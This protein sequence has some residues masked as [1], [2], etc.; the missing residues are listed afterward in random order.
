M[1]A[2][3]VLLLAAGWQQVST[4]GEKPG[5]RATCT[6]ADPRTLLAQLGATSSCIES[7]AALNP[8]AIFGISPDNITQGHRVQQRWNGKDQVV[9]SDMSAKILWNR[10]AAK[11]KT[12]LFHIR[13]AKVV[14]IEN[15]NI[16]T[17][18]SDSRMYDTIHIENANRV[19]VRNSRFAGSVRHYHLRFDNVRELI[20]ENVEIA[21]VEYEGLPGFRGGGGIYFRSKPVKK[22]DMAR[23]TAP[24]WVEISGCRIHDYTAGEAHRNHDGIN[25]DSPGDALIHNCEIRNWGR[26][27]EIADAA[28]DV[29]YRLPKVPGDHQITVTGNRIE[30]ASFVKTPGFGPFTNTILWE[31][32]TFIDTQVADYHGG[33]STV[34]RSN[35]FLLLSRDKFYRMW[36]Q[37]TAGRTI[38]EGNTICS[39]KRLG[40]VYFMNDTGVASKAELLSTRENSYYMQPPGRWLGG[41]RAQIA[42]WNMWLAAGYDRGSTLAEPDLCPP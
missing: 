27:G 17:G 34:Y 20:L 14:V 6:D 4:A 33:Y 32:N 23:Y 8:A 16:E 35:H 26:D 19:I 31:A 5:I 11:Y 29:S 13:R 21:G 40:M 36:K 2:L 22:S 3:G 38:F 12:T 9:I 25:L 30:N 39:T 42:D 18:D 15:L 10:A 41:D 28:I 1:A 24:A 37:K 7:G